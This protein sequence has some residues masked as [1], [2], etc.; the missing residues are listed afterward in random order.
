[1]SA[2]VCYLSKPVK[3]CWIH[4][5]LVMRSHTQCFYMEVIFAKSPLHKPVD[6]SRFVPK[7]N[8]RVRY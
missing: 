6:I 3:Y 5:I 8:E 1:M 4:T 7:Q 2:K